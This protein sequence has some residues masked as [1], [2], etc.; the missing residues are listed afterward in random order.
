MKIPTLFGRTPK[1][2]KF[3]FEP[4]FYDAKK[5]EREERNRRIAQELENERTG[6]VDG[7]ESRIK[8]SFHSARK[9][10]QATS[11]DLRA[12]LMRIVI[13]LF[14]VVFIM[15]YLQWGNKAMYGLLVFLPVYAWMKFKK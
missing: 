1:H 13:I 2:Q 12:S 6:N 10:S 8:G 3:G 7:Y 5:E 15:A 9:R 11:G 4:R 14:L